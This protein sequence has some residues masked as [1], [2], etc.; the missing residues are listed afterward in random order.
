VETRIRLRMALHAGEVHPD[1]HGVAG[2]A[3]V[4][5]FRLIEAPALKSA[6]RASP[7]VMGLVVSDWFFDEVVRHDVSV[8]PTSFRRIRVAVKETVT[9]AWI[10]VFESTADDHAE[11]TEPGPPYQTHK[12][13]ASAVRTKRRYAEG[14]Y[15]IADRTPPCVL[16]HQAAT[17]DDQPNPIPRPPNGKAARLQPEFK[18]ANVGQRPQAIPENRIYLYRISDEP[19]AAPHR[20]IGIITGTIRRV[21]HADIW[22]N[23]ENTQMKMARIEEYSASAIIRYEGAWR[24]S[25]GH[26]VDDIIADE[27]ARKV[28]DRRPVAAGTAITTSSGQ[29]ARSHNVRYLIHVAAVHGEP[30]AGYQQ[31][32]D[33]ERCVTNALIEA[34]S[35]FTRGQTDQPLTSILFPLLGTGHGGG[36]IA[37]TA[38][39]LFGAACDYLT[40]VPET[41]IATVYFLAHTY[42]ELE[43]YKDVLD[44][45]SRF[46]A[47]TFTES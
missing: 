16:A 25:A 20:R 31:V 18:N 14:L 22:V 19:P 41:Q 46:G 23:P 44:R 30:G 5:A 6:L 10:R 21:R 8:E 15:A 7:G 47:A 39:S 26:V 42:A 11:R 28:A 24:D 32:Q 13:A 40:G 1:A 4:R 2:A 12:T 35:I 9:A 43:A 34:D 17:G 38:R 33:V 29:L 37:G 36:N 27:L 3:I 45:N